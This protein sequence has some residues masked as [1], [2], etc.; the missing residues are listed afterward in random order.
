L[1]VFSVKP[2]HTYN[3]QMWNGNPN[4]SIGKASGNVRSET[5]Y[6]RSIYKQSDISGL[7]YPR[8]VVRF[9]KHSSSE[10]L[11]KSQK[12]LLLIEYLIKTYSNPGYVV[13]DNTMGSG[14]TIVA[15]MNTGR[16]AIGIEKDETIFRLAEKR[17]QDHI[18][19][20][21]PVKKKPRKSKPEG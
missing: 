9:G 12:P 6:A 8:S 17:I 2:G 3:P 5:I 11:H 15:S 16:K 19:G 7:K 20:V 13:L 18:N 10:N 1:L 4:H 14:T 21:V